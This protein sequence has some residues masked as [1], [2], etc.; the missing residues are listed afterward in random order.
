MTLWKWVIDGEVATRVN[1]DGSIKS[2]STLDSELAA[3][4]ADGNTPDP[5]H[6]VEELAYN[7]AQNVVDTD[8]DMILD[9]GFVW[10]NITFKADPVHENDYY[11]TVEL[12]K[13]GVIPFPF[14]IKGVGDSFIELTADNIN[15]FFTTGMMFKRITLSDGWAIKYGGTMS[16]GEIRVALTSLT[17]EDLLNFIDPRIHINRTIDVRSRKTSSKSVES[18]NVSTSSRNYWWSKL[19][20]SKI[21]K[22][23]T[24]WMKS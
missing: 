24:S 4:I 14:R 16:T 11:Q 18:S 10:N 3:W 22:S 6:T 2:C 1:S 5:A 21:F 23:I 13:A 8:T 7:I 17:Y 19:L 20:D 15:D 12:L 9:Q